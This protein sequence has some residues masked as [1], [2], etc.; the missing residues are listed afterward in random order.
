MRNVVRQGG[1]VK[2]FVIVGVVL[3]LVALGVLYGLKKVSQNDQTP[4]LMVPG[5]SETAPT[6]S[7]TKDSTDTSNKDTKDETE[8]NAATTDT[9]QKADGDSSTSSSSEQGGSASSG[10]A[11]S[12]TGATGS[13]ADGSLPQTGPTETFAAVTLALITASAVGYIRSLRRLS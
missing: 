9:D 12:A 8:D 2:V 7:G 6:E 13:E 3:T 4:P 5:Q 1:S 11:D 10:T